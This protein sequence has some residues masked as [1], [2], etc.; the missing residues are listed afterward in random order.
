M[1]IYYATCPICGHLTDDG[2]IFVS[3]N[4][5]NRSY[6]LICFDCLEKHSMKEIGQIMNERIKNGKN[7]NISREGE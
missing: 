4:D 5:E 1:M 3:G 2:A 6:Q 7:T